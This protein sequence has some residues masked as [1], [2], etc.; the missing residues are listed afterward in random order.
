[1]FFY[2]CIFFVL[3]V[4]VASFLPLVV[5][6]YDTLW[7]FLMAVFFIFSV[8]GYSTKNN[9]FKGKIS[10]FF[11]LFLFIFLGIWR[12][13]LSLP[14]SH[15]SNVW[16][17]NGQRIIFRG[18]INKEPERKDKNQ[19]LEIESN[20][21]TIVNKIAEGFEVDGKVLVAAPLYPE[22]AYGDLVEIECDLKQPERFD[23]FAYDK[24]LARLGIYSV[25]YF[26]KIFQVISENQ[27]WKII[28]YK[29]IFGLKDFLRREINLGL[30]E[31][32][33]SFARAMILGDMGTINNDLQIAFARTGVS[34]IISISGMHIGI[35]M[36]VFVWFYIEIGFWRKQLLYLM[37]A[38]IFFYV[39]MIGAPPAA[40]R[41]GVMG[42]MVLLGLHFGRLNKLGNALVFSAALMLF[43]N[44]WLLRYDIGFQLSFLAMFSMIYLYPFFD[45][46]YDLKQEKYLWMK[47]R[48]LKVGLGVVVLSI[49]IQ[50]ITAP[51]IILA[52]R[53]ISLIAPVSNLLIIWILP[54]LM[55]SLLIG[56]ILSIIFPS[57]AYLFFLPS[58]LFLKLIISIVQVLEKIPFSYLVF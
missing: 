18:V 48:W 43:L 42:V 22:F 2:S 29:K 50:L 24:Y 57:F 52:F 4:L 34:H 26:P 53:Q 8:I 5:L 44:P 11:L 3:G 9:Y 13:S 54:F 33:S 45:N 47:K 19:K 14:V 39:L 51:I 56:L 38:T 7:F 30:D 35:L 1:M 20:F 55:P 46:F 32:E 40:L 27:G 10:L 58:G 25:C 23:G 15:P 31:P 28:F 36:A 21:L 12:F 6:Q 41:A 17:Y 49:M 37:S 16:F